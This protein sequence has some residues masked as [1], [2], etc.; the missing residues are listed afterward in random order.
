MYKVG[1]V[2]SGT[3]VVSVKLMTINGAIE[4]SGGGES[5]NIF[6]E[7]VE[8]GA[9]VVIIKIVSSHYNKS[10]HNTRRRRNSY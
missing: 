2:K 6:G 10:K 7:R 4:A 9:G 5:Q 8:C 1:R 3:G